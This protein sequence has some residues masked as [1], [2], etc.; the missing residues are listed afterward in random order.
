MPS[1]AAG[2][3]RS[4]AARVVGEPGIGKTRLADEF[5]ARARAQGDRVL[6]GRAWEGGGAP[7]FWPWVEIVRGLVAE[8][9]A[10]ALV[11]LLGERSRELVRL[12][13]ELGERL[14]ETQRPA[15][16]D[17]ERARFLLFDATATLLRVA[18]ETVPAVLVLDDLHAADQPSLLLLRFVAPTLPTSRLVVLVLLREAEVR[19]SRWIAEL[20]GQLGR[21]GRR[22]PLRGLAEADVAELVRGRTGRSAAPAS[23]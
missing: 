18:A 10:D 17:A 8:A 4:S 16:L 1:T 23:S 22:V 20:V 11:S 15:G 7:P 2:L 13:P 3:P 5:T 9:G 21:E 14:P 19:A 12:L 6:W